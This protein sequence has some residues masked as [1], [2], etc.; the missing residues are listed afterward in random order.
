MRNCRFA[1]ICVFTLST[2]ISEGVFGQTFPS[3]PVRVVV[4]W[5]PG[6]ANDITGRVVMQRVAQT[7]GQQFVIDNRAGAGGV[8]GSDIVAKAPADG[9]TIMVHSTSH[10]ANAHLHKALPYDTA[11]DFSTIGLLTATTSALV[12][13]PS[14]SVKSLKEFIALNRARPGEILYGTSGNGSA[15]HM[16][17]ALLASM[18][19]I[20]PVHVPYKGGAAQVISL[21]T[22]EA[23]VAISGIS[24]VISHIKSGRLRPLGVTS[25]QRTPTLPEVPTIAEAGVPG[26]DMN[27]WIAAFAPANTA[28]AA[29]DRLNLEINKALRSTEVGQQLA[30]QALDPWISTP[31]EADMRIKNDL[32]R[33]GKLVK[34]TGARVE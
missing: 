18:T 21:I 31:A 28:I 32:D 27:T 23:P 8:L 13:H 7:T 1:V 14:L 15:P 2:C 6:G 4:P 20:K 22:G 12:V 16:A 3:K 24:V 5:P 17:M 10:V 9:Y 34:L 26:Y 11:K 25:A 19:G 30:N 29:I 33:Y